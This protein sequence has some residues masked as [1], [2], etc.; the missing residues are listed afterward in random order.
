MTKRLAIAAVA[1]LTVATAAMA[2]ETKD[3]KDAPKAK[4]PQRWMW[5]MTNLLKVL[6]GQGTTT[7]SISVIGSLRAI[8]PF[9]SNRHGGV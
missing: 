2:Q 5:L 3:I 1:V 9:C 7:D 8:V 6:Y 4:V